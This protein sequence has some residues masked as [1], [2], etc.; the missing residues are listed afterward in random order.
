MTPE[1]ATHNRRRTGL[2]SERIARAALEVVDRDGAEALSMRGLAADLGVGTMTLY[3]HFRSKAE[4]LDAAVDIAPQDFE[5]PPAEGPFRERL[6]AYHDRVRA[7]LARHPALVRLRSEQPIVR[8]TAFAVSE[9]GMR[10]L[11]DAGFP[12]E[13]AARAFR[14]LFVYVLGSMLFGPREPPPDERRLV[15]AALLSLPED[16]FPAII[17]TADGMVAALGGREQFDFGLELILDALQ[18]RA[19]RYSAAS[20]HQ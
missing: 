11:L 4:L 10:I 12:P 1:T 20:S 8:P 15:R 6:L 3:G 14:V 18:A 17:T 5:A 16:E 19:Q 7:W 2:T 13:E 9:H